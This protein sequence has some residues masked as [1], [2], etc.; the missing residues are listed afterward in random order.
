MKPASAKSRIL[1]RLIS[2]LLI[3]V[4]LSSS[5]TTVYV[6]ADD[7]VAVETQVSESN[8]ETTET[9]EETVEETTET[10]EETVEGTEETE[11]VEGT[12]ETEEVEG[13]SETE[14]GA[15]T[16]EGEEISEGTEAV[17]IPE[18]EVPATET[19]EEVEETEETEEVEEE[20]EEVEEVEVSELSEDEIL[21]RL[22]LSW[23]EYQ[24][25]LELSD[26]ELVAE[27]ENR[28]FTSEDIELFFSLRGEVSEDIIL[29]SAIIGDQR[30]SVMV[31][32]TKSLEGTS[33]DDSAV[34]NIT[35]YSE[36]LQLAEIAELSG[37]QLYEVE[38]RGGENEKHIQF[39]LTAPE[40]YIIR[41][42]KFGSGSNPTETVINDDDAR[43]VYSMNGYESGSTYELSY[44]LMSVN[45]ID[46]R[47]SAITFGEGEGSYID[48]D[49]VVYSTDASSLQVSVELSSELVS[50]LE[51][52][53]GFGV[54]IEVNG[55][56]KTMQPSDGGSNGSLKYTWKPNSYG[57]YRVTRVKI[58]DQS[59]WLSFNNE[60]P[61]YVDAAPVTTL[62]YYSGD[63]I[64]T[65]L[66]KLLTPADNSNGWYSK[67]EQGENRTIKLSGHT[68]RKLGEI[69]V[70]GLETS[71]SAENYINR[72]DA[73]KRW[74][75][76]EKTYVIPVDENGTN[77]YVFNYQ[78]FGD[79]E[80]KELTTIEIKVD[81]TAYDEE[82]ID[83]CLEVVGEGM[84]SEIKA[85]FTMPEDAITASATESGL[86]SF[87]YHVEVVYECLPGFEIP[88]DHIRGR[89]T[90]DDFSNGAFT[91]EYLEKPWLTKCLENI[92]VVRYRVKNVKV[93]D[94]A[95][96]ET[97]K[98]F[99]TP[100]TLLDIFKP[101]V[102]IDIPDQPKNVVNDV[103][104]YDNNISGTVTIKDYSI[105][106]A[107]ERTGIIDLEDW[108]DKNMVQSAPEDTK[109]SDNT[110]TVKRVYNISTDVE[111]G[112]EAKYHIYASAED[113][114]LGNKPAEIGEA[115]SNMM[116][117]DRQAPTVVL[118]IGNTTVTDKVLPYYN[119]QVVPE[120][121]ALTVS[122]TITDRWLDE[123]NTTVKITPVEGE[124]GEAGQSINGSDAWSGE[125]GDNEHTGS[126]SISEN[127]KYKIEVEAVDYAGNPFTK[128]YGE[129][130][131]DNIAPKIREFEFDNNEVK[132]GKYYNQ[133]R[134][135]TITVEDYTFDPSSKIEIT[136]K[137]GTVQP[138]SWEAAGKDLY[139]AKIAFTGDDYYS[140]SVTATDLA[141]NEAKVKSCEEFVVDKTAPNIKVAYDFNEPRNGMYYRTERT[142]TVDIEDI[143]FNSDLVKVSSQPLADATELPQ[144]GG[145]T[146][147]DKQNYAH[148]SFVADGTY[149]YI[150]NCEDLAGNTASAFT[151]DVFVIDTT[152]PEVKFAGVENF[153]ANNGTVAP[154][155]TYVDKYMDMDATVVTMTGSNNG[156]VELGSQI[157]PTENGF[158]VSYADFERVKKMD[159]L[160]TLEATVYD[161][162]GN[163]TKEQLVFSVNRFGSV[164]VLGDAAKALNEE[165]YTNEPK[166]VAIT[167][168]NVDELT[169]KDVSISRDGDVKELKNGKQYQ[170]TKQGSD[171]S[172]KT[173]TYTISKDNFK[174]DGVYSVTVYTKDRAT[175]VQDN[176]SRD[177]EI[178]FAVD[179][180]AP[181]IVAAGLKS[182]ETYKET[183]HTVNID[184]TD[185]MGVT[186]L[187]V[188]KD[189]KEISAYD[190]DALEAAG[191]VESITL[192]ESEN[193]QTI[194]IV[195][196]DVAGNVETVVYDNILVSTKE[197]KT[198]DDDPSATSHTTDDGE[199]NT[200]NRPVRVAIFMI[201]ALGIVA[202]G[203]GAGVTIYKK[204]SADQ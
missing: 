170:V 141:G 105:N 129:F 149:G 117:V 150:I 188:Y 93:K 101:V 53:D 171:T 47:L 31:K 110:R 138:G 84:E 103:Y 179:Q 172:W 37:E 169:Y 17:E 65:G 122:A 10:V 176:K 39:E 8:Q 146:S 42:A 34:A 43:L 19:P 96:N 94:K 180:T 87:K 190:A 173:Y 204:K 29:T 92:L 73:S 97:T 6:S 78:Y 111:E 116:V 123:A 163:E 104:F 68:Y 185:N 142:A 128:D 114:K 189:G 133:T 63:E 45:D 201:L 9:V 200:I 18:E 191:G 145:F 25:L 64:T 48:G 100:E 148:M 50:W 124:A 168:I 3:P 197:T 175:N 118:T 126:V 71:D 178:N 199:T 30:N 107:S 67:V 144:L 36:E 196:E 49:K 77:T 161:L 113:I 81:N 193:K 5:V 125:F 102:N 58:E 82:S 28:G 166:D 143:S 54:G 74:Y 159:D 7:E 1:G 157:A 51:D 167:E 41:K 182:G 152:A 121:Q 158:V 40:G 177:A 62:C 187:T 56:Y 38:V 52:V 22:G 183:S 13:T 2:V 119:S 139:V 12:G 66:T 115:T 195:A 79:S 160:Y 198:I 46:I 136:Q 174:K 75:S 57:N 55:S 194:T 147:D 85:T 153:S 14:E 20:A 120:G 131:F 61:V 202:A 86:E 59:H 135:A 192:N 156:A 15:E 184:V 60:D 11:E 154:S 98:D 24:E 106:T 33:G 137:Y 164:F 32:V 151:S 134:N 4:V 27:L 203:A 16:T 88:L 70:D 132:N 91:I 181:S 155:V 186:N 165:Y 127:G 89:L 83:A 80:S 23:E 76:F 109:S 26:E 69:T 99:T 108:S 130:I 140:F 35:A 162:A 21:E 72:Y 95:G 112:K 44:T 90:S